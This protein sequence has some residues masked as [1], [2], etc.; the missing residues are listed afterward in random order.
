MTGQ[1]PRLEQ[2][3][4]SYFHQDWTLESKDWS[5]VVEH[6]RRSASPADL[7]S[8]AAEIESFVISTPADHALEDRLYREFHCYY[9]PRTDLGGISVRAWLSA[10]ASHLREKTGRGDAV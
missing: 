1:Y 9:T 7:E 6:Y 2:F 3:F 8:V 4:S 5:G 10:V